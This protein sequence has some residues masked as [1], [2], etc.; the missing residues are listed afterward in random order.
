MGGRLTGKNR[1][2]EDARNLGERA[3]RTE[4][5]IDGK[6]LVLRLGGGR[7]GGGQRPNGEKGENTLPATPVHCRPNHPKAQ[8]IVIFRWIVVYM[9]VERKEQ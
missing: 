4:K 8:G 7:G 5:P 3:T 9:L 2:K 6:G 1:K